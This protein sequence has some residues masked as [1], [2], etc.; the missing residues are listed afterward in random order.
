MPKAGI[1]CTVG[2]EEMKRQDSRPSQEKVTFK[3]A[4]IGASFAIPCDLCGFAVKSSFVREY[5]RSSADDFWPVGVGHFA[6]RLVGAFVGVGTEEV[7]LRL[8]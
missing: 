4:R 1:V 8:Q 7:A 5:R 6:A 3:P 2:A